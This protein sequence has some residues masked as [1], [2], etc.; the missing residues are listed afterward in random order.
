MDFVSLEPAFLV[1]LE[2]A[3]ASRVAPYV[4]RFAGRL[5]PH[6]VETVEKGLRH[7]AVALQNAGAARSSTFREVQ[8]RFETFDFIVLPVLSV[9]TIAVG[10]ATSDGPI[11]IDGEPA[12]SLRGG[13]YPYTFPFNLTGHPAIAMPC[14]KTKTGLPIALQIV[15]RWCADRRVLS[16]AA[17]LET[18]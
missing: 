15:G 6:L 17:L 7:S 12:G 14:G 16:A 4:E 3:V 10:A 5:D 2:L 1:I 18:R 11:L 9:A 8:R 13:W